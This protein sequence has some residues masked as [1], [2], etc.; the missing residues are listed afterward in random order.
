MYLRTILSIAMLALASGCGPT[1][2]LRYHDDDDDDEAARAQRQSNLEMLGAMNAAMGSM[3]QTMAARSGTP[4]PVVMAPVFPAPAPTYGSVP[5]RA[6]P[7]PAPA[8]GTPTP[9]ADTR[10]PQNQCISTRRST[11]NLLP[12]QSFDL[13][14]RNN[15][16]VAIALTLHHY[17]QGRA[18]RPVSYLIQLDPGQERHFLTFWKKDQADYE[19]VAC[20]RPT[21]VSPKKDASGR[22]VCFAH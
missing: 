21:T 11:K 22:W 8:Y 14:G 16:A 6:G 10:R 9:A 5:G 2:G 7:A 15:C 3:S 18:S 19:L 13:M 12:S 4:A 17:P 1:S 20:P